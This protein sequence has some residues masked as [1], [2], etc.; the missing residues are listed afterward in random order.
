MVVF[1]Q[2]LNLIIFEV[3]SSLS[4]SMVL[5]SHEN[6]PTHSQ[7]KAVCCF[8][9]AKNHLY[10]PDWDLTSVMLA[11]WNRTTPV[12]GPPHKRFWVIFANRRKIRHFQTVGHD[13][14]ML[15]TRAGEWS[16]VLVLTLHHLKVPPFSTGTLSLISMENIF[17]PACTTEEKWQLWVPVARMMQGAEYPSNNTAGSFLH[18]GN[19][20]RLTK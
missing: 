3:C 20:K 19:S 11:P 12:S 17:D 10:S 6:I 5:W 9:A 13:L 1:G 7:P 4:D 16:Q 8:G 2:R 15:W 14:C 18:T